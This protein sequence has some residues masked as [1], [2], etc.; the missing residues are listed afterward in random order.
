MQRI[1]LF[2]ERLR[3]IKFASIDERIPRIGVPLVMLVDDVWLVL[4][5]DGEN[6][7]PREIALA[8][9]E[10][11]LVAPGESALL[12]AMETE[13]WRRD[14]VAFPLKNRRYL[15]IECEII[16]SDLK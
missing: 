3:K 11:L 10:P 7:L 12:P 2:K 8:M 13:G 6:L 5:I 1:K 16:L 15:F 14:I 4:G 9:I